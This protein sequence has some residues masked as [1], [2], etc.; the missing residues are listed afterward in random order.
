[1]RSTSASGTRRSP[2][3]S[4]LSTIT[5]RAASGGAARP[6]RASRTASGW[7]AAAGNF[8][9]R[10]PSRGGYDQRLRS[11]TCAL[12]CQPCSSR[13]LPLP[14]TPHHAVL[15]RKRRGAPAPS[16]RRA[17][18][19]VAALGWAVRKPICDSTVPACPS[20]GRHCASSRP[21]GASRAASGPALD[22]ARR[23]CAPP[24]RAALRACGRHLRV[25]R[26]DGALLVAG[27]ASSARR[28]GRRIRPVIAVDQASK[29]DARWPAPRRRPGLTVA[30]AGIGARSRRQ[31][32]LE[33]R[34]A[35]LFCGAEP[36][37]RKVSS[38]ARRAS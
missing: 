23:C 33:L 21:A 10:A 19:P 11:S 22:V 2:T 26:A 38:D 18:R 4:L 35:C 34:A 28:A 6:R 25:D 30:A 29:A 5:G 1:M 20:A 7:A 24:G 15:K 9:G 32:A 12:R 13:L 27:W 8:Q 3:F 36:S 16:P 31:L 37:I 14:V 17:G